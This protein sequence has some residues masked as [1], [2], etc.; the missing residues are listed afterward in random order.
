MRRATKRPGIHPTEITASGPVRT[1]VGC[2]SRKSQAELTRFVVGPQGGVV[3]DR[4]R[5]L[6]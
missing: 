2:G 4:R 1:C 3:A 5:K 6:P